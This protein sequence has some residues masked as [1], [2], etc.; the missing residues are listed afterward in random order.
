MTHW[1]RT[2]GGILKFNGFTD[3]LA[4]AATRKSAADPICEALA[5]LPT[6]KESI[7]DGSYEHEGTAAAREIVATLQHHGL[8]AQWSGSL[9]DRILVQMDWKRRLPTHLSTE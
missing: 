9:A 6:T 4:N 1:A 5:I 3:F 7:R 8:N 2:I